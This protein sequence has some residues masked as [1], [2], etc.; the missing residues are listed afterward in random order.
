MSKVPSLDYGKL[1]KRTTLA[2]ILKQARLSVDR[3]QELL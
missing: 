3:L 1:I 2:H